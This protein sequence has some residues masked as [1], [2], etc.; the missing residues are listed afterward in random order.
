MMSFKVYITKLNKS[1]NI[2]NKK[3]PALFISMLALNYPP[4]TYLPFETS[5]FGGC[6]CILK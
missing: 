2:N 3:V 5:T 6:L 4:N 1:L